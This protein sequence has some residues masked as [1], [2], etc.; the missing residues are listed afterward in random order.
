MAAVCIFTLFKFVVMKKKWKIFIGILVSFLFLSCIVSTKYVSSYIGYLN[1]RAYAVPSYEK[2]KTY[3][4]AVVLGGFGSMNPETGEIRFG[5]DFEKYRLLK[6]LELWDEGVVEKILITGDATSCIN[7]D[8]SSDMELFF[9]YMFLQGYPRN[10]FVIEPFAQTTYHNALLTCGILNVKGAKPD[11]CILITSS[12]H[13]RRGLACFKRLG[14]D[15]PYCCS[16]YRK[17]PVFRWEDLKPTRNV[18]RSWKLT[19]HEWV[20]MVYYWWKGWI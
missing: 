10:I 20:G 4:Y 8:G 3:K 13:M 9:Q 15:M 6:A 12:Y 5:S 1:D 16:A 18:Y 7:P 14:F 2:G 17:K 11:E 19:L